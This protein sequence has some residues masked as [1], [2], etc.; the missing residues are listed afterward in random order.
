MYVVLRS[1]GPCRIKSSFDMQKICSKIAKSFYPCQP[2]R[3]AQVDMGRYFSQNLSHLTLYQ[4]ISTFNNP[5]EQNT[6][7]NTVGKEENAGYQH[8]LLFPVLY[9]ATG[10]LSFHQSFSNLPRREIVIKV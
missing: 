7:Q 3:I 10:I 4:T 8:F 2:A 1:A 5:R 9:M 6:F